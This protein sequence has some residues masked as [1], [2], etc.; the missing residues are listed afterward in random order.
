MLRK[1]LVIFGYG[2]RG[3]GYA[4]FAKKY[5]D[6]FEVVAV[7]ETDE[8]RICA[9]KESHPNAL[10]FR[11]YH[12]F[13]NAKVFA[14]IVAV[15]T[16]DNQHKE[17]AIAM[18]KA[19]YDLLLE[20]PIA[21]KKEDCLEIYEASKIYKKK[22]VVCHVLRYTPFYSAVKD[23]IDNGELG[24]IVTI[25]TSENV[26]YYHQAHSYVRGPWRNSKESSP[27]I[28]AKCCHDMDIIR[29]M[30]G[31]RCLSVNSYGNLFYF[32]RKHAPK[33][34]AEYCSDCKLEDC[35]YKAQ[36]IYTDP[37]SKPFARYFTLK[38][39][40]DD[41]LHDL[42]GTQYDKCV[43]KSDND[44][45]DH[46][47]TIMQFENG[48]TASH[49]MTA[50]SKEIYR[51]I[52]IYGTKAELEGRIDEGKFNVHYFSGK[53]KEV[54]V[55]ISAADVGGHNGGDYYLMDG[56]YKFLNGQ[57]VKGISYLS[58]SLESHLMSFGA[59]ES[60]LSNGSTV[61]ISI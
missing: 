12:E 52:K 43:F 2:Q 30:I 26:G 39:D 9:V 3:S 22:V 60:R 20:K 15:A 21:N 25:Q 42:R 5:P 10:I 7:I 29:Y 51:D 57:T 53:D 31:E 28:L 19:G 24:E 35:V 50:F 27:M 61:K 40:D 56:L 11:D 8:N 59:E 55:D 58:V 38:T 6:K 37:K 48:K 32:N 34:S 1:R 47:V 36:K 14:D 17:H 18:I 45:V 23:Y 44:V 16:Q 54:K 46:Q 49:T 4:A 33:S 41:I 13:I